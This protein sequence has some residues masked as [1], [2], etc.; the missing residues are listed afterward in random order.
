MP[1][2]T[3]TE[4]TSDPT[5]RTRPERTRVGRECP[6]VPASSFPSANISI[7]KT[8]HF[9]IGDVVIIARHAGIS[10]PVEI[11]VAIIGMQHNQETGRGR[12]RFVEIN[13]EGP[14]IGGSGDRGRTQQPIA[15]ERADC[16][17]SVG[18]GE[19]HFVDHHA[20]TIAR[21][22]VNIKISMIIAKWGRDGGRRLLGVLAGPAGGSYVIGVVVGWS[23]V[24]VIRC[25]VINSAG[26]RSDYTRFEDY[27]IRTKTASG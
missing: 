9:E 23:G 13:E 16:N 11:S 8:L 6:E 20:T 26:P 7:R 3:A 17:E 25:C 2:A 22:A 27:G 24:V 18:Q 19:L 5:I 4:A 12:D 1:S 14:L 10:S 15:V 21:L